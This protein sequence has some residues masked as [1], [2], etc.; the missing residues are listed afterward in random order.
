MSCNGLC[1]SPDFRGLYV[2]DTGAVRA[3]GLSGEF[4]P[5]RPSTIYA[6]DVA[7]DG[8]QLANRRTF[9]F[10]TSGVP[11]GIKCDEKGNVYAGCGDGIHVWN[12]DG[13]LLGKIFT[14]SMVANFNFSPHGI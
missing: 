11:D 2:T 4:D 12:A 3:N 10:C 8:K 14:H 1:F 13:G 6:Y 5:T 7:K 9:A